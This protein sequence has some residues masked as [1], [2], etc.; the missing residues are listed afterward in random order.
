ME[1]FFKN[2]SSS[3]IPLVNQLND[4]ELFDLIKD[5]AMLM[6]A[7]YYK[8]ELDRSI[9]NKWVSELFLERDNYGLYSTLLPALIRSEENGEYGVL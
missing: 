6:Y 9:S 1:D 4:S 7:N 3:L 8:L 5:L 2:L